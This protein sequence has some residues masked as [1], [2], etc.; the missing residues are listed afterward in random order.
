[1]NYFAGGGFG[2]L[3]SAAFLIAL[4]AYLRGRQPLFAAISVNI[5]TLGQHH[6]LTQQALKGLAAL[7][8]TFVAQQFVIEAGI[9][10]VQY[11]MFNTA[12]V[13]IYR[14][15]VIGALWVQHSAV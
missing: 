7:N 8:Q 11:R 1:M 14:Q 6:A 13:L 4:Y 9:E 5:K 12:Y 10:Q 15:P 2:G 3:Y